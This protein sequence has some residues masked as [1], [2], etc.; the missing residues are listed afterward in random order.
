[1]NKILIIS[2]NAI[3]DTYLSMSAISSIKAKFPNVEIYFLVAQN[4]KFLFEYTEVKFVFT[5]RKQI[6]GLITLA[7]KLR[8]IEFDYIFSFF[9]GIVNTFFLKLLKAN[10]KGGYQ[11]FIKRNHWHDKNLTGYIENFG[12]KKKVIWEKENNYLHLILNI[13]NSFF[14][15]INIIE[16]Y[17]YPNNVE[18]NTYNDNIVIHPFSKDKT[19]SLSNKQIFELIDFLRRDLDF[20]EIIF[21]GDE[22]IQRIKYTGVQK[23]IKPNIKEL[24]NLVHCKL[25]ISVDSFPLHIA[26]AYNTNFVGLFSNTLPESVLTHSEK[27][28]KFSAD[29]LSKISSEQILNNLK[30]F[31]QTFKSK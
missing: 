13:L 9:P 12:M 21:I 16:K 14:P 4:S 30:N 24:I 26:D 29:D 19:R 15:S 3:G 20:D 8:K 17:Q 2:T 28:I 11:N 25:F 31:I 27:S 23:K 1:M 5:I 22:K 6:W 7:W 10:N 18:G